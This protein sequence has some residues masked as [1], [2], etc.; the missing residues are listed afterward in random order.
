MA[1]ENIVGTLGILYGG[2]D[3]TVYQALGAVFSPDQR[4]L[5]PGVQPAVRPCF[6]AIGAIKREMNTPSGPGSPLAISA[7]SLICVP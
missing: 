5:L 7:A 6:A 3:E 1:K 4:L 2:G